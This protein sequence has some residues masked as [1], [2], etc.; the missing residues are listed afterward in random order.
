M[1]FSYLDYSSFVVW[2]PQFL[3]PKHLPTT[4]SPF[5]WTLKYSTSRA[6]TIQTVPFENKLSRT[7]FFVMLKMT[8][9]CGLVPWA[10][11]ILFVY[12]TTDLGNAVFGFPIPIWY[13]LGLHLINISFQWLSGS[14]RFGHITVQ[15]YNRN[16]EFRH[17]KSKYSPE[18]WNVIAIRRFPFA[19]K[20]PFGF[21]LAYVVRTA[22]HN[23]FVRSK[24]LCEYFGAGSWLLFVYDCNE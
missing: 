19:W 24:D 22:I 18:Y 2:C 4:H 20:N 3:N 13:V 5:T 10:I 17:V 9:F 14:C 21:L 7:I 15:S 8:P 11:Y 23:D 6:L 16:T 1:D 12:F